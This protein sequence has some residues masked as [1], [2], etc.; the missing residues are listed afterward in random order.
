MNLSLGRTVMAR[1][2]LEGC[3]TQGCPV[4]DITIPLYYTGDHMAVEREG[5]R[6]VVSGI[7]IDLAQ[8]SVTLEAESRPLARI[9]IA[10]EGVIF[11]QLRPSA[12]DI[13]P[14][15]EGEPVLEDGIDA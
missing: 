9:S 11:E 15:V 1:T 7:H 12:T 8:R 10:S 3:F 5:R 4:V 2:E 13:L 6:V 14:E